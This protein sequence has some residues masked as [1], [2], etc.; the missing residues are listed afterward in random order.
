MKL[1]SACLIAALLTFI[2]GVSVDRLLN[3]D[4]YKTRCLIDYRP[5]LPKSDR[6]PTPLMVLA[7]TYGLSL[8]YHPEDRVQ[9]NIFKYAPACNMRRPHQP[10]KKP[11]LK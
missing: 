3:P 9:R 4:Y 6:K 1:I 8:S 10:A 5:N 2:V 11:P 7:E